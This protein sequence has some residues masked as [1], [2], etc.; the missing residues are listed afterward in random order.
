MGVLELRVALTVEDFGA[1]V[2]FYRNGL[3]LDPGD[4]WTDGGTGQMLRAGR[5]T[6]EIFD[7]PYA[8]SVDMLEVGERVSG[9]IRLA[10]EVP[11]VRAALKRALRYGATLVA[12]PTVTPWGDR[13]ARVRSPE[14]LQV[15]LYE[16][17]D[18]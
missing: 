13:S 14:G 16:V 18:G 3:G 4:L 9:E 5:G 12:D 7:E 10:F 8:R 1:A 15:T 2:R 17:S 11:D 6:L